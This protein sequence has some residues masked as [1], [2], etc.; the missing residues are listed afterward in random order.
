MSLPGIVPT[1]APAATSRLNSP[2][3]FLDLF[4]LDVN[5]RNFAYRFIAAMSERTH[6]GRS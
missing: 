4:N 6:Y 2:K 1:L 5:Q 3:A